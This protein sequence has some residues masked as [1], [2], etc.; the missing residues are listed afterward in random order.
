MGAI[1]FYISAKVWYF[2]CIAK[3]KDLAFSCWSVI[4]WML[5]L[6]S[7]SADSANSQHVISGSSCRGRLIGLGS[8]SGSSNRIRFPPSMSTMMAAPGALD[9]TA[10]L[11]GTIA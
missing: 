9:D 4:V 1:I 11:C 6:I 8:R 2:D 10:P 5:A 7:A 3:E